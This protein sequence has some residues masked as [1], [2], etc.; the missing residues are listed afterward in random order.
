MQE[1]YERRRHKREYFTFIM[2]S[3]G[4]YAQLAV[5]EQ[6]L[7]HEEAMQE[8]IRNV[9]AME[10]RVLEGSYP[11]EILYGSAGYLYTLLFLKHHIPDSVPKAAIQRV[12]ELI[13]SRAENGPQ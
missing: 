6:E 1:T 10:K 3:P 4:I 12:I 5:L 13:I 2:G 9:L 8:A 11:Y 7:G